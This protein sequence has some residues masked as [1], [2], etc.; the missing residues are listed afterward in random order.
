[1]SQNEPLAQLCEIESAFRSNWRVLSDQ[2]N[3]SVSQTFER[4]HIQSLTENLTAARSALE[5]LQEVIA[6]ANTV[7]AN[8]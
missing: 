5:E 3:D 6:R 4:E 1:M 8:Q 2:W 7:L